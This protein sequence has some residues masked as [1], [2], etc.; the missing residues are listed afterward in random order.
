MDGYSD[1]ETMGYIL[2]ASHSDLQSYSCLAG[3]ARLLVVEVGSVRI[4][5]GSK[6]PGTSRLYR[7]ALSTSE[8]LPISSVALRI[9]DSFLSIDTKAKVDPVNLND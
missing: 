6:A 1:R 8:Y 2:L 4:W 9:A 3:C 7:I 5:R